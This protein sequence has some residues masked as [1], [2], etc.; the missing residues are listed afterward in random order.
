[1]NTHFDRV[2]TA[3]LANKNL[4][5]GYLAAEASRIAG[6]TIATDAL[7]LQALMIFRPSWAKAILKT[8]I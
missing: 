6:E 8:R 2:T 4:P 7:A 5:A 1:M 3:Y